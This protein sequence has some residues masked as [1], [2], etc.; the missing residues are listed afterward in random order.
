MFGKQTKG[1]QINKSKI[2]LAENST[3]RFKEYHNIRAKQFITTQTTKTTHTIH[4]TNATKTF[5]A[6]QTTNHI[7]AIKAIQTHKEKAVAI[8]KGCMQAHNT[9]AIAL[10]QHTDRQ[11][12]RLASRQADKQTDRQTDRQKDRQTDSQT[13]RQTDRQTDTQTN[14]QID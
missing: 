12:Y 13:D 8:H 4:N 1:L 3:T 5:L 2:C 7:Q 14:R 6:P 11:K 10:A 9:L